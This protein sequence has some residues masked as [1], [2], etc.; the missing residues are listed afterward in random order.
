[1]LTDDGIAD[2]FER[3]VRDLDPTVPAIVGRA[4]RMGRR[5]R[6]RF[7]VWIAL[8]CCVSAAAVAGT[9]L[10]AGVPL[11]HPG[12]APVAAGGTS[13]HAS[14]RHLRTGHASPKPSDHPSAPSGSG[15]PA[16]STP[17][18]APGYQMTIKQMLGVLRSLLPAGSAVSNVNTYSAANGTLEVDYNDGQGAVDLMIEVGPTVFYDGPATCPKPLW[19]NEGRRPAGA[20]P[21][22]CVV[23]RLPDG[24]IERDAVMYADSYGFY[25]YNI[26]DQRPDGITVFIQVGNGTLHGLPQV[27]RA[28]PPGSLAEWEA[29]AES[30]LWHLKKGWH[31]KS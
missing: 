6:T 20:L 18:L 15:S 1:M 21:M 2:L 27:D 5:L 9:V 23:R 3:A 8:G 29:V 24:S 17:T 26:Y 22:S 14:T 13:R 19:P 28:R 10:A 16:G 30:P 7:R 12:T 4:E 25:D 11:A 31:L